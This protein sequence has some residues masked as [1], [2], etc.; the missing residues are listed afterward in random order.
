MKKVKKMAVVL[1]AF[2]LVFSS[3]SVSA[4]VTYQSN[5]KSSRYTGATYKVY[6]NGKRVNT[7]STPGLMINQNI[8]IPYY[9][10]LVKNGPKMNATKNA[11]QK[12]LTLSYNG[13]TAV[14]YLNKKYMYVNQKS[15]S[16]R[17]APLVVN[18]SGSKLIFVPAKALCKALGITYK[19]NSQKKAVYLTGKTQSASSKNNTLK[20]SAFKKM[21]T[22]QFIKAMGPIAQEDYKKTGILASVTI[23][24]AINESGWGKSS[25]SQAGNNLF[26]MKTYI[27][28]NTWKGSTWDGHS[29][30]NVTKRKVYNGKKV[31]VTS[32]FRKYSSVAQSVEDHAAYLANAMNGSKKR[33]AGI[34]KTTS[35][36]KQLAILKKG[37]Y[38]EGSEYTSQLKKLIKQYNL[39]KW[40]EK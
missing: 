4:A 16:L 3:I 6:Y 11:S 34:T 39:T 19:Y 22:S 35:Y 33:Y 21:S 10:T 15:T 26:G 12:K 5:G 18:V 14:M 17:T 23:A 38:C 30:V 29:Y 1:M 36:T 8:M 40:D 13:K 7:I 31:T 24:Q 37:G 9:K 25:L 32:K 28:G 2:V 20:A 27:S